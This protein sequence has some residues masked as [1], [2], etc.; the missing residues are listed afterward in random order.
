MSN[1][2]NGIQLFSSTIHLND[3][4]KTYIKEDILNRFLSEY[5]KYKETNI[6][7]YHLDNPTFVNG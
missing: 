5:E 2:S 1:L 3:L 7:V 6:L 4:I